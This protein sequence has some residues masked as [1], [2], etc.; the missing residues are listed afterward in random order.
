MTSRDQI[1]LPLKTFL[2]IKESTDLLTIFIIIKISVN[3][4]I[5]DLS[6]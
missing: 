6:S 3:L 2:A 1:S 4:L 5:L